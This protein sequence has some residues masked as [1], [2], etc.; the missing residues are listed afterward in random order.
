M[1]KKRTRAVEDAAPV[2][3]LDAK[4][5]GLFEVYAVNDRLEL[6]RD[7]WLLDD[8][9]DTEDGLNRLKQSAAEFAEEEQE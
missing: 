2:W 1:S 9:E 8:D 5:D 3:V 7:G 4:F 6:R